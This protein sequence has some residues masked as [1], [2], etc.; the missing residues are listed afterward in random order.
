MNYYFINENDISLTQEKNGDSEAN[1][2][3][4]IMHV[5]IELPDNLINPLEK[6]KVTDSLCGVSEDE[7]ETGFGYDSGGEADEVI[8]SPR[9]E[10]VNIFLFLS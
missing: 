5:V 4:D 8:E 2:Q 9:T 7:R 3:P 6:E 1:G 10:K